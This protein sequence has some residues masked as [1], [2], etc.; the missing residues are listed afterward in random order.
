MCE[1]SD[2]GI[3]LERIVA[4]NIYYLNMAETF[5][6]LVKYSFSRN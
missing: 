6:F 4:V 5:Y 1:A 2:F 3:V